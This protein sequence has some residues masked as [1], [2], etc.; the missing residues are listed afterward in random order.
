[1]LRKIREVWKLLN[2]SIYTGE[3]LRDNLRAL[4]IVSIFTAILGLVLMITDL[5]TGD[6]AMFATAFL[7]FLSGASCGYL[8]GVRKNREMAALIP[9]FF[10][11]FAFTIYTI[12]GLG[13]GS[14][15]LWSL[16]APIGLCYFV[17]VRNG[18]LVSLYYTVFFIY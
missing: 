7:T 2:R 5:A 16:M 13:E 4:T 11:V 17:S 9:T 1:M 14:A 12:K 6:K 10:C 3:R 18:I 15:M 8:A